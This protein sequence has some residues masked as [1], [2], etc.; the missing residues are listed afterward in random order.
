MIKGYYFITDSILSRNGNVSDVKAAVAAGVSVVQYRDK[1]ADPG[2]LYEEALRL[3]QITKSVVFLIN[4]N[5]DIAL[6]V[7]A[8]G[9]HLGQKDL[10]YKEARRFLGKDKII[11]LTVHNVKEALEAQAMGADYIGVSPIFATNTKNDAGKA[12]GVEMIRRIRESV[13]IPIVAIGG[14]DLSNAKE[15]VAAGASGLCAIS[16]VVT[17][18]DVKKEIQRFQRLF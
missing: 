4:D 5:V 2:K 1:C 7:D 10:S 6:S 13:K 17:K 8:D 11:G 15:V 16:A 9:V 12:V 18:E 3:R 14:I